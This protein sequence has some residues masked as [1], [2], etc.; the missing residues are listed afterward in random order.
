[1][2]DEEGW[3]CIVDA[4]APRLPASLHMDAACAPKAQWLAHQNTIYDVAWAKVRGPRSPPLLGP[5]EPWWGAHGGGAGG[6]GRRAAEVRQGRRRL[7]QAAMQLLAWRR[8]PPGEPSAPPPSSAPHPLPPAPSPS[9]ND[10]LLYTASGDHHVGVWDTHT[11]ALRCYCKGHA[12]S[13]KAVACGEAQPDVFASGKGGRGAGGHMGRWAVQARRP[14]DVQ[15]PLDPGCVAAQ[16]GHLQA[17]A[18]RRLVRGPGPNAANLV[19]NYAGARDGAVL[20]WDL[21]GPTHWSARHQRNMLQPCARIA[22]AAAAT[23]ARAAGTQLRRSVTALAFLPGGATLAAGGDM[24]GDVRLW[25]CRMLARGPAVALRSPAW[26]SGSPAG[27]AAAAAAAAVG[28]ATPLGRGGGGG[29]ARGTPCIAGKAHGSVG[30]GR[31]SGGGG[32]DGMGGGSL[33]WLTV[34]CPHRGRPHGI[35][36]LQVS[37]AGAWRADSYHGSQP[38]LKHLRTCGHGALV[39][40]RTPPHRQRPLLLWS[41]PCKAQRPPFPCRPVRSCGPPARRHA[42]RLH[43]RRQPP[44]LSYGL[45][46]PR[47]AL[48]HADRPPHRELL[49]QGGIQPRRPRRAERLER[50]RR[51]P[52]AGGFV[53]GSFIDLGRIGLATAVLAAGWASTTQSRAPV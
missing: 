43:Q 30:K 45:H 34:T 48:G 11:A 42:A 2:A 12:G 41:S 52:V 10:S 27:G 35:T 32:D 51:A 9:Q 21:R 6:G 50:R 29:G 40:T 44:P 4:A 53:F 33:P 39:L 22:V 25:D 24:D 28:I 8:G 1:V 14:R 20:L 26:P 19:P 49:R 3:V 23:K 37:P 17:G 16:Q 31:R 47:V 36:S 13:V 18:A 38:G 15:R 7:P 46:G 5:V